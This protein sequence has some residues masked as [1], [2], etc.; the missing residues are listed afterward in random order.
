MAELLEIVS[1]LR[2]GKSEAID[3]MLIEFEE[4]LEAIRAG[5][6]KGLSQEEKTKIE[7]AYE[8]WREDQAKYA[9]ID[10][11]D[12]DPEERDMRDRTGSTV[13]FA[14]PRPDPH[15]PMRDYGHLIDLLPRETLAELSK[16]L[17]K[18]DIEGAREVLAALS[19]DELRKRIEFN[20]L[21]IME[22]QRRRHEEPSVDDDGI[23]F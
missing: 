1:V 5:R 22:Q 16:H 10:D 20:Q 23:P 13:K 18:A 9:W 2:S 19:T 17:S 4:T 15:Q 7:A 3:K 14:E 11:P 21:P 12:L 8:S 6:V